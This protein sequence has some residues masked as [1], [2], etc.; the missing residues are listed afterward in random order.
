M[1]KYCQN[2]GS[3]LVNDDSLFCS[4]CGTKVCSSH[5]PQTKSVTNNHQLTLEE[6]TDIFY[7]IMSSAFNDLEKLDEITIIKYLIKLAENDLK[8]TD[9]FSRE[10][11]TTRILII[12]CVLRELGFDI[13]DNTVEYLYDSIIS[14]MDLHK[15]PNHTMLG[16]EFIIS[17]IKDDSDV[18]FYEFVCPACDENIRFE[19][20]E[21]SLKDSLQWK[22][23]CPNCSYKLDI[24][25]ST[26]KRK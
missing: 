10:F 12:Q 3:Q 18:C 9:G 22:F 16:N 15:I 14:D 26:L 13:E 2:C 17:V 25:Q 5:P 20:A 1:V 4:R 24:S 8:Q 6:A 23:I 19:I 21:E 11:R 7:D